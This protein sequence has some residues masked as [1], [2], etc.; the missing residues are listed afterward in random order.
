MNAGKGAWRGLLAL[1]SAVAVSITLLTGSPS[2]TAAPRQGTGSA[3]G[4]YLNPV[5]GSGL[6]TFPDPSIIRAKDGYWYA[7]GTTDR[8]FASHGDQAFHFMPIVRSS[9]LVHWTYVGDVWSTSNWPS[10]VPTADTYFWASDLRYLDGQYYLYYAAASFSGGWSTVGVATA[11]S[12]AGPWT[13]RGP[14]MPTTGDG[15]PTGDIDP[16][17]FTDVDGTK[18]LYWGSGVICVARLTADGTRVAEPG[19][20][21][22]RSFGEGSYVVRR[23]G[24]YYLFWSENGCCSIHNN[25]YEVR[26][27]RSKSPYGPFADAEGQ[28]AMASAKGGTIVLAANGNQWIGPGHMAITTDLSGQTWMIYHAV[29]RSD[30]GHNYP[31]FTPL[32]NRPALIDRLDWINGWPTVRAGAWASDTPQPAPVTRWQAGGKITSNADLSGNWQVTSGQWQPVTEPGNVY[33]QATPGADGHALLVSRDSAPQDVHAEA[34][35]RIPAGSVARAGLRI[36][37]H[38]AGN[39]IAAWLDPVRDALVTDVV[40][41]GHSQGQQATSLPAGFRFDYWHNV[42]IER[43]AGVLSVVVTNARME[44]PQAE[45]QRSLPIATPQAGHLAILAA[46]GTV[47]ADN[48]G[49]DRLYTPVTH[50]VPAPAVG[51]LNAAYSDEFNGTALGPGWSWLGTPDGSVSSGAFRWVAQKGDLN[52]GN[53]SVLLR[54]PPPGDWTIE[55][56]LTFDLGTDTNRNYQ[57][58]GL[59]IYAD[60]HDW[61][62]LESAAINDTRRTEWGSQEG[63]I[64]GGYADEFVGPPA[65]TTWLRIQERQDPSTGMYDLRAGSSRDGTHW[66]WGAVKTL[67]LSLKIRIGL[68]SQGDCCSQLPPPTAI[69][70]YFRLYHP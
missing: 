55:T 11:A 6:D 27:A 43:R 30:N 41:D 12:P 44:D 26:V 13:D 65:T 40:I 7:I 68:A 35:L 57:Q 59:V 52:T 50:M 33:V 4:T 39:Y 28:P 22:T 21:L 61:V 29:D 49:A 17:E 70:D 47:D 20:V 58:A 66:I 1:F 45:Q 15:C 37:Y 18:Y 42:A 60:A 32:P 14:V 24:Y 19:H 23:D 46:G 54:D 67:P 38:D 3:T 64:G 51:P 48:A 53:A 25:G 36:A 56:K 10:W 16:A 2:A 8:T 63:A 62:R 69:F 5:I 31:H 34:D 9:D